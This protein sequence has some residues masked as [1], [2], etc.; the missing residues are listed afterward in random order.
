MTFDPDLYGPPEYEPP[1]PE[2][3]DDWEALLEWETRLQR[4]E[5]EY[6]R[7]WNLLGVD[8]DA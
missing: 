2:I 1:D 6:A 5:Q 4:E 3:D 8:P 7:V